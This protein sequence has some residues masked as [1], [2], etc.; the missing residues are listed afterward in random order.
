MRFAL[1]FRGISYLKN[2]PHDGSVEPFDVNFNDT[3]PFFK[4][5]IIRPL[6]DNNHHVDIFFSTYYSEEIYKTIEILK[7]K[8]VKLQEYKFAPVGTNHSVY[9]KVLDVLYL[10]KDYSQENNINYDFII[11]SRFDNLVFENITNIPIPSNCLSTITPRDDNFFIVDGCL[12]QP[13]TILFEEMRMRNMLTH[14]YTKFFSENGIP[15]HTIYSH[16][17]NQNHH[18]FL[19]TARQIFTKEG[20]GY[21]LCNFSDIFNPKSRFYGFFYTPNTTFTPYE[22]PHETSKNPANHK[23]DPPDMV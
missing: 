8:A 13:T 19:K 15:C 1:C 7:P 22:C 9:N 21:R 23:P 4:E 12:L 10:V 18:P 20:H 3:L 14:D 6:Q 16:A 17:Y 5:N 2:F 11:V